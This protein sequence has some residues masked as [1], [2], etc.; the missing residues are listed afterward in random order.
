MGARTFVF[1]ACFELSCVGWEEAQA[2]RH[3]IGWEEV[4]GAGSVRVCVGREVW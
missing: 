1:F 2:C 3:G 4:G